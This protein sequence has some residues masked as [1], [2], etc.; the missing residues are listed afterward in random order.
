MAIV[1]VTTKNN[2]GQTATLALDDERDAERIAYLKTLAKREDLES[3]S[4]K[5]APKP[6]PKPAA[7]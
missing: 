4:V 7:K 2:S 5:P 1:H 3:V 6:A